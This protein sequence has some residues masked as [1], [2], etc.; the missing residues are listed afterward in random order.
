MKYDDDPYSLK[1]PLLKGFF[2]FLKQIQKHQTYRRDITIF[3]KMR[4]SV[5]ML[6]Q[7]FQF[8]ILKTKVLVPRNNFKFCYN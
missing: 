5:N 6:T 1:F 2:L 8:F 4:T 3:S 7:F